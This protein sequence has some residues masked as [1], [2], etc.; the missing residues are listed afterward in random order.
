MKS[1]GDNL[2]PWGVPISID[3]MRIWTLMQF[4][5]EFGYIFFGSILNRFKEIDK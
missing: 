5:F 2:E 1:N 4:I 3:Q